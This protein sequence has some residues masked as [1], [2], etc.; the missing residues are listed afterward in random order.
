MNLILTG[1]PRSGKTTIGKKA[2]AKLG[3]LFV[4]TDGLIESSYERQ[5]KKRSTCREILLQEGEHHFRE[6][7]RE[8][9]ASLKK[10]T[11]TVIAA[12]GGSLGAPD[13]IENLQQAGLMIYLKTSVDIIWKR[14]LETGIPAFL[15]ADD[16]EKSF[17]AIAKK[18][19][20]LYEAT[21]D[22]I[23]EA[24]TLS[25]EKIVESVLS[26]WRVGHGK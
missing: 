13:N 23:I 15:D 12:G 26:Y 25:E 7:E 20:P 2:A 18:R 24:S 11:Q 8:Q 21:A 9:I 22:A 3:W 14:I 4:D 1:L 5:T 16:P 10:F 19:L 17:Y 6:L